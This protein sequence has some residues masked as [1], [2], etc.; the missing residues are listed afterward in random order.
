MNQIVPSY[1]KNFRCIAGDCRHSCCIGWEIDVDDDTLQAYRRF[2]DIL[3]HIDTSAEPAHFRLTEDE[4][5]PFLN[6]CGLCEIILHHGEDALCQICADHPRFRNFFDS[7][8]ET[9]LGL[10]CEAAAQLILGT[11]EKVTLEILETDGENEPE[12]EEET[13][14]F[15]LRD[16]LFAIAQDRTKSIDERMQTLLEAA[17]AQIPDK[18]LTEWAE[19]FR[20]L[21]CLDPARDEVLSKIADDLP[22]IYDNPIPYEQLLVY[23]LYRHLAPAMDDGM[24][25]A[26][27]AFAVLST[28]MIRAMTAVTGDLTDMARLYSSEVEYSEENLDEILWTLDE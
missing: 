16:R 17:D 22:E 26:R 23:F 7:R 14:F 24:S 15:A 4:R 21:E 3:R 2:P 1:Y 25:A 27:T 8:T 13:A 11:T 10:C 12:S 6:G 18:S 28:R 9:G 20:N 5:C 19:I